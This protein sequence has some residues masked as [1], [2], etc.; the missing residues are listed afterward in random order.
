MSSNNQKIDIF[1]KILINTATK[2]HQ[3]RISV[4]S[5]TP[6]CPASYLLGIIQQAI[7]SVQSQN[8]TS[9]LSWSE[10]APGEYID[11]NDMNVDYMFHLGDE[12]EHGVPIFLQYNGTVDYFGTT[13]KEYLRNVLGPSTKPTQTRQKLDMEDKI[14]IVRTSSGFHDLLGNEQIVRSRPTLIYAAIRTLINETWT[15]SEGPQHRFS[16]TS[17]T[18]LAAWSEDE[19]LNYL[20]T[21]PC[22]FKVEHNTKSI[23]D[24]IDRKWK[25]LKTKTDLGLSDLAVTGA[26][27]NP[28]TSIESVVHPA[29]AVGQNPVAA[30]NIGAQATEVPGANQPAYV[31]HGG[32]SS[33][34]STGDVAAVGYDG[35]GG[36]LNVQPTVPSVVNL[37]AEVDFLGQVA[38]GLSQIAQNGLSSGF[39]HAEKNHRK[40]SAAVPVAAPEAALGTVADV[41]VAAPEA[42]LSG[43]AAVPAAAL[44]NAP[45]AAPGGGQTDVNSLADAQSRIEK[46][47]T[48]QITLAPARDGNS[49]EPLKIQRNFA[50]NLRGVVEVQG[51]LQIETGVYMFITT[52]PSVRKLPIITADYESEFEDFAHQIQSLGLILEIHELATELNFSHFGFL[53]KPSSLKRK[54]RGELGESG[55]SD[56]KRRKQ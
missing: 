6:K 43:G 42:A 34:S 1:L 16:G 44:V 26:A 12:L 27:P 29:I 20:K 17:L 5:N 7:N 51:Y 50:Q 47:T 15:S 22:T 35:A 31:G 45:V 30:D 24:T 33:V 13:F 2:P 11:I 39:S 19:A 36:G 52:G 10:N 21:D 14:A 18:K 38:S 28:A 48:T 40:L 55:G 4:K 54:C 53:P 41:P 23:I 46:Q 8:K 9:C 37:A 3:I 56:R 49:A 32:D 25:E